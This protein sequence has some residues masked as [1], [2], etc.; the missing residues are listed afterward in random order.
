MQNNVI[1]KLSFSV[2][3]WKSD[4]TPT[5]EQVLTGFY[6]GDATDNFTDNEV[7]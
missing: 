2:K 1:H 4:N 3:Q 7:F 5:D 6:F